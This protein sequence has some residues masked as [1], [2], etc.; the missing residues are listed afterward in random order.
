MTNRSEL[1]PGVHRAFGNWLATSQITE[2]ADYLH[3]ISELWLALVGNKGAVI[4]EDIKHR[5]NDEIL[6]FIEGKQ[7]I[8]T[9]SD[10]LLA[11]RYIRDRAWRARR[12]IAKGP[13][14]SGIYAAKE[15]WITNEQIIEIADHICD[16]IDLWDSVGSGIRNG[17]Y[18]N[19][20][21]DRLW[22][23]VGA[24]IQKKEW[25]VSGGDSTTL[26]D[27]LRE[28]ALGLKATSN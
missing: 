7:W 28:R 25:V 27:M 16:M 10:A 26:S 24:F 13:F 3:G 23:E 14:P 20:L 4:G 22:A 11:A 2:I 8:A 12:E 1:K 9:E 19:A 17:T 21:N 18:D 6:A 15:R 5:M